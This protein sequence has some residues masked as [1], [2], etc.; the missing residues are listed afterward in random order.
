MNFLKY[1]E[2]KS[3]AL[4]PLK[5][6]LYEQA[7]AGQEIEIDFNIEETSLYSED[8]RD[9]FE[10]GQTVLLVCES[11]HEDGYIQPD[12]K[13]QDEVDPTQVKMAWYKVSSFVDSEQGPQKITVEVSTTK[14]PFEITDNF[15]KAFAD[16]YDTHYWPEITTKEGA[17]LTLSENAL[18]QIAERM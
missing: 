10:V 5:P 1:T 3:F 7:V 14:N 6:A 2:R 18:Q 13:I 12:R 9:E 16:F 8:Y 11:D 15:K 17:S 4:L